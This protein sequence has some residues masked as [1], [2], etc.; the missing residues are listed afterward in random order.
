[1][2]R[3]HLMLLKTSEDLMSKAMSL[4]PR[5]DYDNMDI[6]FNEEDMYNLYAELFGGISPELKDFI[7]EIVPE[8]Y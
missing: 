4:I 7:D 6:D 5:L 2:A 1:M 3:F 8:Y